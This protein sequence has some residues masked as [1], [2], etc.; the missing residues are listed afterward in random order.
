MPPSPSWAGG[1]PGGA[2][3]RWRG[4]ASYVA[5]RSPVEPISTAS[6]C[7]GLS[8]VAWARPQVTRERGGA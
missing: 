7:R 6:G 5:R 8:M 1:V 4:L 2:H 3:I